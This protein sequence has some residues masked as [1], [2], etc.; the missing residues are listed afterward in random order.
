MDKHDQLL[1]RA[2][3]LI[4]RLEQLLSRP[5]P[6]PDWDAAIAFRWRRGAGGGYLEAIRHPHRIRLADLHN[7]EEQKT[8]ITRNTRQFLAR[9]PANNVLLWGSRGTGKSSLIKA[10]LTEYAG[11]GLRVIE[12]EPRH[13]ADLPDIVDLVYGRP[14]RYILFCDDLSFEADDSSYKALKAVL[15]GSLAGAADNVLVYATSNR[16]H[17]LPEYMGENE[18][19]RL[20][21]GEIHHGEAVEEKIS[22]SERF[23]LWLSFYPFSQEHYLDI[24]FSWLQELQ[25]PLEDRE[26]VRQEALRYALARGS[27]SGRVAW[28]F[29]RDWAGRRGLERPA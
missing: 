27:R 29:A 16:R 20:R 4:G 19:A 7:I 13:L 21:G 18:Q 23:G 1:I 8:G 5:A 3:Q 12:I 25:V 26:T 2:E 6:Q 17:L 14:E 10:L 24:C 15:D 22:L 28:Q 11:Q 9:L